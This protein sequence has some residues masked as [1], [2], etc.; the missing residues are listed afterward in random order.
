MMSRWSW[1]LPIISM[2][3]LLAII[4]KSIIVYPFG[5]IEKIK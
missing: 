5:L 3:K 2:A 4:L 1:T